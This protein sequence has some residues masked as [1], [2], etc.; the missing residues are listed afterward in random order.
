MIHGHLNK[1]PYSIGFSV[2]KI[3][4]GHRCLA[5]IVCIRRF[6]LTNFSGGIVVLF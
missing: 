1:T 5:S 6:R 2:V 4:E 3:D